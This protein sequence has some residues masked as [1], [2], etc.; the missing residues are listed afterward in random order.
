[1]QLRAA[2][3]R[4]AAVSLPGWCRRHLTA[5]PH[6]RSAL[7]AE[8]ALD[9]QLRASLTLTRH[10]PPAGMNARILAACRET[11]LRPGGGHRLAGWLKPALA[12]AGLGLL[13]AGVWWGQRPGPRPAS[14][15]VAAPPSRLLVAEALNVLDLE[16][17]R[18]A[19]ERMNDPLQRELER[20]LADFRAATQSLAAAFLPET[21]RR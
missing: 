18:R 19:A 9:R 20:V 6:C 17:L 21:T 8:T 5:C 2:P 12:V 16:P 7:A 15:P 10:P 14:P 1:V 13:A 4:A 11:R 3:A